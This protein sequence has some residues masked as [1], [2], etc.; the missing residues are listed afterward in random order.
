LVG[1]PVHETLGETLERLSTSFGSWGRA[2]EAEYNGR[3]SNVVYQDHD[4]TRRPDTEPDDPGEHESHAAACQ[5]LGGIGG[6]EA[7]VMVEAKGRPLRR[8]A[9]RAYNIG[10]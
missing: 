10:A 2:R 7:D 9:W 5:P 4:P 8:W 6:R 3:L 1:F